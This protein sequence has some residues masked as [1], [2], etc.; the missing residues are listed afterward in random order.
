MI[1]SYMVE[2]LK[3]VGVDCPTCLYAIN[4]S[5]NKLNCVKKFDV[6][7]S[8][9]IT[10][11]EY[12]S[13]KCVLNDIYESIRDSGYD[14]DKN[15]VVVTVDDLDEQEVLDVENWLKKEKGILD[16][17]SSSISKLIKITYNPLTVDL[18]T[19][20][21]Y[22]RKRKLNAVLATESKFVELAEERIK[23]YRR[24]IAF[25][26]GVSVIVYAMTHHIFLHNFEINALI[27]LLISSVIMLLVSDVIIRGLKAFFRL[28]PTMESFIALSTLISF[29]AGIITTIFFSQS[30]NIYVEPTMFFEASSGVSGFVSF[31]LFLEERLRNRAFRQLE[32][33]ARKIYGRARV[34]KENNKVVEIDSFSIKPGEIVEVKAGEIIPVD[35]VVVE[36]WGYVD[37]SSFTGESIPRIKRSEFR[38]PVLGGSFLV[39]GFIRIKATRSGKDT[40]FF[41]L[42]ET[43]RE[44]QFY[45]PK[46][47]RIA[48]K[49]VKYF[50]WSVI[51]IA[52][53]TFLYWWL[54]EN[55]PALAIIFTVSVFAVACPCAL[56]IAVP[57]VISFAV[58]KASRKGVVIRRGDVFERMLEATMIL[59]DKTGTLT[60]GKPTVKFVHVSNEIGNNVYY[61]LCSIESRSEHPLAQSILEYC[62]NHDIKYREPEKYEHIPGL[63]VFGSIDGTIVAVGSI[64]FMNKLGVEF[65][66]KLET[67]AR[68]I[69]VKGFTPIIIAINNKTVGVIEISDKLREEAPEIITTLK[70]Q[71]LKTGVASGDIAEVTKYYAEILDLDF[72]YYEMK[73][74]DKIELV[75]QLEKKGEKIVFIGDGINDAAAIS[76]SFVGIAMGR[77]ADLAK[78]AGDVILLNNQLNNLLTLIKLSKLVKKKFY[79]NILWAF[80][81]NLTLIPIAMGI[82]YHPFGILIKPE[83]AGL[84]MILSDISVVLNSSTILTTKKI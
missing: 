58:I 81:Y 8:T 76:R 40:L 26:L 30:H 50:T 55:Q 22:F 52:I 82:L 28:T 33:I 70:K 68:S 59:F 35:G 11:I 9:G 4:R 39:S 83:L 79:Q 62:R 61:Y 17:K 10:V 71:G 34:L 57:L 19:V 65:D 60:I 47:V 84:A 63:G 2:K 29:T 42:L 44:A 6:D 3:L 43:I 66:Q 12:D 7:I 67:L 48:D 31:G 23:F 27:L 25:I 51:T 1:M 45:K 75:E 15:I 5:L 80:L 73:P 78:E 21:L 14:V 77:G 13:E 38:D 69:G 53:T 46:V 56:G 32:E 74:E 64:E 41:N 24:I 36:G 20:L 37:E 54:V 16:V 18:N 49:L 72:V